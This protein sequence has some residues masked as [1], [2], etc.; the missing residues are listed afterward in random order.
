M[1]T[2]FLAIRWICAILGWCLFFFWWK[3]ASTPGWVSPTAVMYSLLSIATVVTAAVAYSAI[4]IFHN[5]RLARRGKRGFVSFYKSP[6]FE[7]DALG[8]KLTLPPMSHDNY[9]SILVVRQVGNHKSYV[10]EEH[11][12]GRGANA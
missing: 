5:K 4:W 12:K 10:V 7:A 9:D 11:A 1:K 3:K 8:R 2:V 6:H